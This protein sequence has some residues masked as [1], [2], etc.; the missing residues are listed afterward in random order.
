MPSLW[1]GRGLP[2]VWILTILT[3]LAMGAACGGNSSNGGTP[4]GS[5]ADGASDAPEPIPDCP[6]LLPF[7]QAC[8]T[9]GAHCGGPCVNSWQANYVCLADEWMVSGVSACGPSAGNPPQCRNAFSSGAL[10]PC[11]PTGGLQCA[12]MPD[13]YPGFGCT[14][15][16]DSFCACTCVGGTQLCGC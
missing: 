7:G 13:G 3:T 9:A 10:T 15:E 2:V 16:N 1:T 14:P 12:G 11:C 5:S 6:T 8:A 4:D